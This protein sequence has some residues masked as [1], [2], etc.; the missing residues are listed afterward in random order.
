MHKDSAF[1]IFTNKKNTTS[2]FFKYRCGRSL[3]FGFLES[4]CG[5]VLRLQSQ[6]LIFV[7]TKVPTPKGFRKNYARAAAL[8][9]RPLKNRNKLPKSIAPR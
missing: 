5:L 4:F 3:F 7:V 1:F 8:A 6:T 9:L 2:V